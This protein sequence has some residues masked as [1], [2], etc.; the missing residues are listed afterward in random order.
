MN[1]EL[2]QVL[3]AIGLLACL[4]LL[5]HHALGA[6]RQAALQRAWQRQSARL[7]LWVRGLG[8]RRRERGRAAR[9]AADLIERAK[10]KAGP[11]AAGKRP[12]DARR[13]PRLDDRR[14][15]LH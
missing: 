14:N 5:L 11:G 12:G 1:S 4:A 6:R 9:E 13:S 15:D 3:A 2:A 7:R 8:Q 10:R